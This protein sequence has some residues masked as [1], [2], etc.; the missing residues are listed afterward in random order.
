MT[1]GAFDRQCIF[2][3]LLLVLAVETV[4]RKALIIG[5]RRD[6]DRCRSKDLD[7]HR[8]RDKSLTEER[9]LLAVFVA[10]HLED[11]ALNEQEQKRK[12]HLDIA[13]LAGTELL[14]EDQECRTSC[15]GTHD[16]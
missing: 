13:F 7:E 3:Y 8:N 12:S 15:D 10:Y 14:I 2:H 16:R 11:R 9:T 4:S 6:R 1:F 5:N